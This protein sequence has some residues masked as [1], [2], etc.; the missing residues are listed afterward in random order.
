MECYY[1][2][3]HSKK[4]F[5]SSLRYVSKKSIQAINFPDFFR[6]H[7][8]NKKP[9]H[10]KR[11]VKF[12]KLNLKANALLAE[13]WSDRQPPVQQT[14]MFFEFSAKYQK[15]HV[16]ENWEN[17]RKTRD[18]HEREIRDK[19]NPMKQH[20]QEFLFELLTHSI[21]SLMFD[22]FDIWVR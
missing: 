22:L 3:T 6:S 7:L 1:F 21:L 4:K 15:I 11:T 10:V 19:R 9:E 12:R 18:A 17:F 5:C 2:L 20:K 14:E 13:L 16:R 8:I